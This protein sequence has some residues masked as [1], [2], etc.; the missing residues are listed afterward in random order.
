[1][2]LKRR[3]ETKVVAKPSP[4]A[5]EFELKDAKA[6]AVIDLGSF[7]AAKAVKEQVASRAE[8]LRRVLENAEKLRW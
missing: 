5:A 3:T 2:G 7:V 8:A 4:V 1:M 6:C